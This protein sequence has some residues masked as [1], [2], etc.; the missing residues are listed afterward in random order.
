MLSHNNDNFYND[1]K[2]YFSSGHVKQDLINMYIIQYNNIILLQ[3][4][5][6]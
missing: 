3:Y 1:I 2:V 4:D 5:S 6:D